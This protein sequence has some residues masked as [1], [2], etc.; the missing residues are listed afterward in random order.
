M[1]SVGWNIAAGW[2]VPSAMGR[3]GGAPIHCFSP[4]GAGGGR[5]CAGY[6]RS[7]DSGSESDADLWIGA[8]GAQPSQYGVHDRLL[9]RRGSGLILKNGIARDIRA[10]WCVPNPVLAFQRAFE[11]QHAVFTASL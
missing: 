1:G 8:L 2:I 5:G 9:Q 10:R 7:D 4:R 6:G 3:R 11:A